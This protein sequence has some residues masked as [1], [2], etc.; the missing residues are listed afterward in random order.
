MVCPNCLVNID[1][2]LKD[3]LRKTDESIFECPECETE[4]RAIAVRTITVTR[5]KESDR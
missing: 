1:R 3:V 5:S 2:T 4:L